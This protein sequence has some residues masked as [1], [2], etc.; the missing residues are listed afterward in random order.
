M[1]LP[2]KYTLTELISAKDLAV[3]VKELAAQ[4]DACYTKLGAKEILLVCV[5]RGAC[6]FYADLLRALQTPVRV[7]FLQ[8]SSYVGQA[9]SG[10]LHISKD[11]GDIENQHVLLVEDIVDTGFT[12]SL[13]LERLL[14]RR[15]A[16]LKICA[17]LDKADA[18]RYQIP[19]DFTGFVAPDKFLV[20]Y[21]LDYNESFRN[22]PYIGEIILG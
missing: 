14:E 10:N 21:G 2:E 4:I 11:I 7:D 6:V 3:K 8:A 13:L 17:L 19:V 15:P 1:P 12:M 18:R 20:G 16:S 22:L 5:L 9:S